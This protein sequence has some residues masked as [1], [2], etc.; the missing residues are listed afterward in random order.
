M[1]VG[2]EASISQ[3]V[4]GAPE[5]N[6][7]FVDRVRILR[8]GPM[9]WKLV[10]PDSR[11]PSRPPACAAE[12]VDVRTAKKECLQ[13][14][15]VLGPTVGVVNGH[16]TSK[17][18]SIDTPGPGVLVHGDEVPKKHSAWNWHG[19]GMIVLPSKTSARFTKHVKYGWNLFA[20]GRAVM[21]GPFQAERWSANETT[22]TAKGWQLR[23]P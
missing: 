15:R 11:K 12:P 4:T 6:P 19:A 10:C 23:R 14:K 22:S 1:A 16:P 13:I 21:V 2:V 7:C 17:G 5:P 18:L 3:R 9:R 20:D 8:E